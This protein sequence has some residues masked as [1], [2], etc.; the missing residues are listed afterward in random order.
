MSDPYWLVLAI[1]A[2]QS[3]P[4]Y[5]TSN[6]IPMSQPTQHITFSTNW[7]N[8]LASKAYTTIRFPNP[9]KFAVGTL[10]AISLQSKFLHNARIIDIRSIRFDQINSYIS[11]LDTG[12]SV[13]ECKDIIT[14]MYKGRVLPSTIFWLILLKVENGK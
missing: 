12:Y 6:S 9:S 11:Y 7:N 8:K 3:S 14:K 13:D 5:L 4:K 10:C 2:R 1:I